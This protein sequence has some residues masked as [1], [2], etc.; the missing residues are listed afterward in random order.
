[1][2]LKRRCQYTNKR[3][4]SQ[5]Y[6][7]LVYVVVMLQTPRH[8]FRRVIKYCNRSSPIFSTVF[9]VNCHDSISFR[10]QTFVFKFLP[11]SLTFYLSMLCRRRYWERHWINY[12]ITQ[13]F[14]FCL[15]TSTV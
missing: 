10:T 4:S 2:K 3:N 8:N 14:T 1:M 7:E 13:N 12:N 6:T 11:N 9:Q 15:H 5:D